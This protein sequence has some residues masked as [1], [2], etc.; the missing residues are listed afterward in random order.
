MLSELVRFCRVWFEGNLLLR[1]RWNWLWIIF[2][3]GLFFYWDD[4]ISG[5]FVVDYLLQF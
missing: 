2:N 3:G 1:G 5:F 4:Y